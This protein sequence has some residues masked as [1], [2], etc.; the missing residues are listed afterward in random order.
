MP[1]KLHYQDKADTQAPNSKIL[2][3]S[4]PSTAPFYFNSVNYHDN[5]IHT[6]WYQNSEWDV[7]NKTHDEM[8]EWLNEW[9]PTIW[10]NFIIN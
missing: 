7:L 4:A 1:T 10:I 8:N 6:F 2:V 5:I 3:F 9:G